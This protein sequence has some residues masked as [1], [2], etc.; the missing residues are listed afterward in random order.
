M[1]LIDEGKVIIEVGL[2]ES[3]M[4]DKNPNI[5]YGVQEVIRDGIACA[6][7]GAAM[8]HFHARAD[9]GS[10]L[11]TA[12]D[13]YRAE[14]EGIAAKADVLMYPS[15]N[16]D[17]SHIWELIDVPPARAELFMIPFDVFQG[18]G[19]V[20]WDGDARRFAEIAFDVDAMAVPKGDRPAELDEIVARGKVPT[21]CV[22]ELGDIRWTGHA[23]E[24]GMLHPPVQI[25]MFVI[26]R[27]IK[28]A[29]PS[30]VGIDALLAHATSDMEPMI[31]PALMTSRE[32]TEVLL[33]HAMRRGAHVRVGI[34][35]NPEAFPLETN[36]ELVAWAVKLAAQEGLEPATAEDV[37]RHFS[38]CIGAAAHAN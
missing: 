17:F 27:F 2:N 38:P 7:A 20:A 25:K 21:V 5:P 26:D 30:P 28:G 1:G 12:T 37:R 18:V 3:V 32:R 34:G 16:G 33:R 11:W 23:V 29:E 10:Q 31:V 36:A 24:A 6:E 13:V 22:Q 9:D 35:D 14:M 8:L 4:K 19:A 15:Y